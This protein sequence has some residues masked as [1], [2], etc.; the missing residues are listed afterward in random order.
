M[1]KLLSLLGIATMLAS[2]QVTQTF[3][4]DDT[5]TH[6]GNRFLD[7][8]S[9][10]Q[11]TLE[12]LNA[13]P[14]SDTAKKQAVA[15]LKEV[16]ATLKDLQK[17]EPQWQSEAVAFRLRLLASAISQIESGTYVAKKPISKEELSQAM[18]ALRA[19]LEAN[20]SEL[21]AKMQK[22]EFLKKRDEGLRM[23]QSENADTLR[24]ELLIDLA[25]EVKKLREELD[26]LKRA[27]KK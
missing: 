23:L 26:E 6:A 24:D 19:K 17:K 12:K 11:K 1:K 9:R 27:Q 10:M 8:S 16:E 14:Q 4:A 25:K 20:Q 3:A 15:E 22:L 21:D 5:S 18:N 13:D 7:A 2:S